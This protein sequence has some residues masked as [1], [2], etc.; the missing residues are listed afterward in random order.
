MINLND[1]QKK[2]L[3]WLL[4]ICILAAITS[5]LPLFW[6][7]VGWILFGMLL[8]YVFMCGIAV[9]GYRILDWWDSKKVPPENP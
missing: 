3:Q 2:G 6:K 1:D 5:L 7:A 4:L 9:I 8:L